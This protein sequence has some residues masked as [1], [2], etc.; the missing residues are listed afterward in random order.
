MDAAKTNSPSANAGTCHRPERVARKDNN[1]VD[2]LI[3][4]LVDSPPS[5]ARRAG[6]RSSLTVQKASNPRG[7]TCRTRDIY[8]SSYRRAMR[9]PRKA[10]FRGRMVWMGGVR[11][12]ETAD[13]ADIAV[14]RARL[15]SSHAGNEGRHCA[16]KSLNSAG[17]YGGRKLTDSLA[18]ASGCL[19][20]AEDGGSGVN[21]SYQSLGAVVGPH[22]V[23]PW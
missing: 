8:V 3:L 20:G 18:G 19:L 4:S 1:G 14:F 7:Q 5:L 12:A 6:C 17:N 16:K 23:V 13:N 9:R 21:Q 11:G 10:F 2:T 22:F 15:A